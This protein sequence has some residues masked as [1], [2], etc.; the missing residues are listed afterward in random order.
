MDG[1][2]LSSPHFYSSNAYVCYTI[3]YYFYI[4]RTFV[5]L[6]YEYVTSLLSLFYI[7]K[8]IWVSL[9]NMFHDFMKQ[10][11]LHE[12]FCDVGLNLL[13]KTWNIWNETGFVVWNK[14]HEITVIL[15]R[16]T[17]CKTIVAWK[18]CI[19]W[20]ALTLN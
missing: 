17:C 18:C 20:K 10:F 14:L 2:W 3:I 7:H 11:L 19:V 4:F 5:N 16:E 1:Q 13:H 12:I 9:W 8:T 15:L 6:M